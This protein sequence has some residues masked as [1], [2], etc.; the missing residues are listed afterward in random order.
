MVKGKCSIC[1]SLCK[2]KLYFCSLTLKFLLDV[3]FKPSVLSPAV[4][5]H[6]SQ[7]KNFFWKKGRGKVLGE[8]IS[9]NFIVIFHCV[10]FRNTFHWNT[11]NVCGGFLI[12][13]IT[14]VSSP[15][16]LSLLPGTQGSFRWP[17]TPGGVDNYIPAGF[18]YFCQLWFKTKWCHW[19]SSFSNWIF[20]CNWTF[21]CCKLMATL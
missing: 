10:P 1:K 7:K 6:G 18:Y 13:E 8:P 12:Y 9:L 3:T 20:C 2:N 16:F 5:F 17:W 14:F 15:V 21:I 4:V 11:I 19:F